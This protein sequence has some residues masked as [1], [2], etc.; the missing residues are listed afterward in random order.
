ML[1]LSLTALLTVT[2]VCLSMKTAA[3]SSPTSSNDP[4]NAFQSLLSKLK[5]APGVSVD[6]AAVVGPSDAPTETHEWTDGRAAV[7]RIVEFL[8]KAYR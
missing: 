5:A 7:H 4:S 3:A 1:F 6:L 2:H 8:P